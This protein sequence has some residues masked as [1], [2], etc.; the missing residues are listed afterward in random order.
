[1]AMRKHKELENSQSPMQVGHRDS[2]HSG[3][4]CSKHSV[5]LYSTNLQD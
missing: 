5:C 4:T 1:M 2:K 3:D